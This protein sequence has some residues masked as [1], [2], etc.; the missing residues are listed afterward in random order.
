MGLVRKGASA[1]TTKS[2]PMANP[3]PVR[4]AI[5]DAEAIKLNQSPKR[6]TICPNQRLRQFALVRISSKYP[7]EGGM[8]DTQL[9][10][11][12]GVVGV[13]D[14]QAVWENAVCEF[15]IGVVFNI[16]FDLMPI[17]VIIADFFAAC[18]NGQ[19]PTQCFDLRQSVLKFDDKVLLF[20]F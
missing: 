6:L 2:P 16:C 18:T 13:K 9:L 15:S 17:A 8:W 5:S 10:C 7:I 3:D 11:R 14:A 19:K 1:R 4:E 12:R 20:F